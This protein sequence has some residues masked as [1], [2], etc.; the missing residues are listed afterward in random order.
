[1]I[2]LVSFDEMVSE[3]WVIDI[4]HHWDMRLAFSPV[5]YSSFFW[6]RSVFASI[7]W[8]PF[9]TLFHTYGHLLEYF[10]GDF[11]RACRIERRSLCRYPGRRTFFALQMQGS[12]EQC[13][14]FT[15]STSFALQ[16]Q[17]LQEQ[18]HRFTKQV[19]PIK[20]SKKVK[21]SCKSKVSEN[22]NIVKWSLETPKWLT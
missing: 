7:E 20:N 4:S 12:Q 6:S 1:M 11:T 8:A 16:L 18:S 9:T 22:M 14:R 21:T 3:L 2:S 17:R 5:A 13:Y 19:V 10:S 15:K